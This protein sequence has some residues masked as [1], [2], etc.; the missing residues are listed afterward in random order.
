MT[1][2]RADEA[3]TWVL[4]GAVA[5]CLAEMLGLL[6]LLAGAGFAPLWPA[7]ISELHLH[8][9]STLLGEIVAVYDGAAALRTSETD[10]IGGAYRRV[11]TADNAAQWQP[12]D[13]IVLTLTDGR[14]LFGRGHAAEEST[15]LASAS[16]PA[17]VLDIVRPNALGT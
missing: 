9:G 6:G 12:A 4:A 3:G 1:R 10:R 16:R 7:T 5:L 8:D 15:L 17:E 13:A 14:R 2:R 11:P